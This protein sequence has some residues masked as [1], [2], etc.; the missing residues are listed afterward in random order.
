MLDGA[1]RK[2]NLK[3]YKKVEFRGHNV[4]ANSIYISEDKIKAIGDLVLFC[5]ENVILK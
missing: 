4:S 5:E 1:Q 2:L 3:K